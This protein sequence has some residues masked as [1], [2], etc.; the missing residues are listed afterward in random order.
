MFCIGNKHRFKMM[1][2]IR[3]NRLKTTDHND[4]KSYLIYETDRW[5]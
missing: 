2:I 1:Q 5:I 4:E 3:N